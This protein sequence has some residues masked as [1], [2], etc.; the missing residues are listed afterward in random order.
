MK[1]C[2]FNVPRLEPLGGHKRACISVYLA[3]NVQLDYHIIKLFWIFEFLTIQGL[4]QA[5]IISFHNNS[6]LSQN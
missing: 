2:L 3:P 5:K 4:G 6:Q 1:A